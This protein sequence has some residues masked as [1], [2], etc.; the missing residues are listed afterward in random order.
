MWIMEMEKGD[1]KRLL[2]REARVIAI[3]LV[4]AI[5]YTLGAVTHDSWVYVIKYIFITDIQDMEPR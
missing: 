2:K 1:L 5:M 3:L 4:M